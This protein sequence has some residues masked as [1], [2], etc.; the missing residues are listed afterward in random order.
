M[1]T[2]RRELHTLRCEMR[3]LRGTAGT[4]VASGMDDCFDL[5]RAVDRYPDWYPEV[6]RE[7][8]V[9]DCDAAGRP[10]R[11]RTQLHIA[12]GPLVH[13]F[14]LLMAVVAERPRTVT[15]AKEMTGSSRSRFGVAWRL[16]D[17][18]GTHIDLDLD[19]SLNVPRFMPLG[20]IGDSI[21]SGFVAAAA[22]AVGSGERS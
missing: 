11:A 6:V 17:A 20:G 5:L 22:R 1:R 12:R 3:D 19:A 15:L 8:E 21:A 10:T 9:L 7:V 2:P 16:R 13:D 14:D 4:L 18:G